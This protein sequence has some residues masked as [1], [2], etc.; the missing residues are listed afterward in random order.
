MQTSTNMKQSE[1]ETEEIKRLEAI[2]QTRMNRLEIDRHW[3]KV[4]D[5]YW[6]RRRAWEKEQGESPSTI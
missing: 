1:K 6:R 3:Q 2:D 5:A 4:K